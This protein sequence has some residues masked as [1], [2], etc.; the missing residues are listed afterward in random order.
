MKTRI[1]IGLLII[2]TVN[3]VYG[4]NPKQKELDNNNVHTIKLEEEGKDGF[5]AGYVEGELENGSLKLK[6]DGIAVLEKVKLNILAADPS[7]PIDISL[8]KQNWEDVVDNESNVTTLFDR[9]FHVYGNFGIIVTSK[10]PNAKF[11]VGVFTSPELKPSLGHLFYPAEEYVD[12]DSDH[13]SAVAVSNNHSNT[14]NSMLMYIIAVFLFIIILLLLAF[15]LRKRKGVITTIL[16]IGIFSFQAQAGIMPMSKQKWNGLRSALNIGDMS[17]INTFRK[18][19]LDLN[20]K[21]FKLSSILENLLSQSNKVHVP[22]I[23]PRGLPSLPSSCYAV[24][25]RV[26]GRIG[27]PTSGMSDEDKACACLALAYEEFY[28]VYMLFEKLR[29]I[30]DDVEKSTKASVAF[31]DNV[32]GGH[33]VSGLAWQAERVKIMEAMDKMYEAY[34]DKLLEFMERMHENLQEI[35]KCEHELGF[36]NWYRRVGFMYYQFTK[37]RYER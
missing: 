30:K 14:S 31:G 7:L 6:V 1:L 36:P 23:D 10:F 24:S 29:I 2:L 5:K 20:L 11:Y 12:T 21:A 26:M 3:S 34:D 17:D 19:I 13:S 15:L 22:S 25:Q 8:V 28:E 4:T 35:D 9:S 37:V 33:A 27:N 16:I 18:T 32:S